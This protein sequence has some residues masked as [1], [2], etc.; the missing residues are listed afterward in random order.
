M[1]AT[2]LGVGVTL[3][4]GLTTDGRLM[5]LA[6]LVQAHT[7]LVDQP[8]QLVLELLASILEFGQKLEDPAQALLSCGACGLV[9]GSHVV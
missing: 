1:S 2:T 5:R 9:G 8:D 3:T 6:Y 7:Q 4:D